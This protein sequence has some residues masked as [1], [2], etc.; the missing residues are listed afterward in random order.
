MHRSQRV[1]IGTN[2]YSYSQLNSAIPQGSWLGPVSFLVLINDVK[3]DC[4]VHKYVDDTTL[5][6]LYDRTKPSGIQSFFHQLLNWADQNEMVVN[7]IKTKEMTFGPPSI[8]SNLPS[9]S[10][11]SYQI[12]RTSETK[13]LGPHIDSD[14]SWHTHVEAIVSKANQRLYFLKQLQ[15]VGVPCA[16]LIHFYISVIRPVLE[17]AVPVW[18]HLLTK[19]HTDSIESVQKR[20]LS[21]IYSF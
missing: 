15:R 2:Y 8:T 7:L 17:Y 18:H 14:L 3:P 5:T 10:T 11:R 19:T 9:I 12:Q 20:A 13:Q 1:Q 6:G 16:Q 4:L 21:I